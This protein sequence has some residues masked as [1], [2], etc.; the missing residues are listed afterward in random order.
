[1]AHEVDIIGLYGNVV[2][3]G[4]AVHDANNNVSGGR[5]IGQIIGQK[6]KAT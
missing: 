1:M 2:M 6:Q 5:L 4:D 3:M